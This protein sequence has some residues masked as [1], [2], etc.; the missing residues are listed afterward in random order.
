MVGVAVT[1]RVGVGFGV[2]FTGT[3]A[4]AISGA[5]RKAAVRTAARMAVIRFMIPFRLIWA[6]RMSARDTLTR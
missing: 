1:L 3:H 4:C 6:R 2:G 5:D